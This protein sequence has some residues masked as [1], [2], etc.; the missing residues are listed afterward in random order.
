MFRI[1]NCAY[2]LRGNG[3]RLDQFQF[4]AS[5]RN[6]ESKYLKS[7]QNQSY[8]WFPCGSYI[9]ASL[10]NR[11]DFLRILGDRGESEAKARRARS[12]SGARGEENCSS[13]RAP[14]ALRARLAFASVR[15]IHQSIPAVP[16]PPPGQPLGHLLTLSVPG[17]RH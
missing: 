9:L 1:K 4:Q 14:L 15:L 13:P 17:V 6:D 10:Q 2:N 3:S 12:A 16:I 5:N 11:R 7:N 8:S